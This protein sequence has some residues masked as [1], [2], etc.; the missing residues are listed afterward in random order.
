LAAFDELVKK[1]VKP[2]LQENK[3]VIVDR[4]LDSTFVYQ[5]LEGNIKIDAIQKIA[6]ETINLP[7]PDLTFI[8]DI[9]P[10]KAQERL[11]KRKAEAGE[12]TNWDNL[13]LDFHQKIRDNY[14]KLKKIFP[15]R[16]YIINAS[17]SEE[18]VVEEVAE[19]IKQLQHPKKDLPKFV[20]VLVYNEKGE[21]LLVKDK[22]WG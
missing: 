13:K 12:Y 7:L 20:R 4:Y 19:I 10:Q 5:G 15:E 11:S 21:I 6:Q 8:L 9:E 1:V 16:I 18:E 3:I 2:S 22:K 14:L 17:K